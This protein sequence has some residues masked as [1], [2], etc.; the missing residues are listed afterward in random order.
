MAC[1]AAFRLVDIND[2]SEMMLH[3]WKHGDISLN[4][5]SDETLSVGWDPVPCWL[6]TSC[7]DR[8][9]KQVSRKRVLLYIPNAWFRLTFG[10]HPFAKTV[11]ITP[12]VKK[13]KPK[14]ICTCCLKKTLLQLVLHFMSYSNYYFSLCICN[15]VS[16]FCCGNRSGFYRKLTGVKLC[17]GHGVIVLCAGTTRGILGAFGRCWSWLRAEWRRNRRFMGDQEHTLGP[18]R[19]QHTH[20]THTT[21]Q[22]WTRCDSGLGRDGGDSSVS[23]FHM[24]LTL[25]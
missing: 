8:R 4:D 3:L 25:N 24:G 10:K 2:S 23:V 1:A 18:H 11:R 19:T 13:K 9:H 15:Y 5:V 17:S 14:R 16:A 7:A 22:T 6:H 21:Q 20:N 12:G